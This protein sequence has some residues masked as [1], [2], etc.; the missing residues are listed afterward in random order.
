MRED[1][2]SHE[3]QAAIALLAMFKVTGGDAAR[4]CLAILGLVGRGELTRLTWHRLGLLLENLGLAAE[5]VE[6]WDALVSSGLFSQS[7]TA[8]VANSWIAT[9]SLYDELAPSDVVDVKV[10]TIA[11]IF[12]PP[13]VEHHVVPATPRELAEAGARVR[14]WGMGLLEYAMA[15]GLPGFPVFW[16]RENGE[17]KPFGTDIGS[18]AASDTLLLAVEGTR[19][20][21]AVPRLSQARGKAIARA[22]DQLLRCG[23]D[24][25]DDWYDG[26][27]ALNAFDDDFV[28][29]FAKEHGDRG[30]CPTLDATAQRLYALALMTTY[31]PDVAPDLVAGSIRAIESAAQCILRWQ[32]DSGGWAI[33]RYEPESDWKMP[34][35]DVSCRHA[36][37][38]LLLLQSLGT[39][40]EE[41]S[42]EIDMALRRFGD[43][44]LES[45]HH[46]EEQT[47]WYGDFVVEEAGPRRRAT[48]LC[49][50]VLGALAARLDDTRLADLQ[51][52]ATR[53]LLESWEPSPET[54]FTVE[55]RVP[56]W[57]GPALAMFTWEPPADAL[58]ILALMDY[59]YRGG[60]FTD[61]EVRTIYRA[62]EGILDTEAHGSWLDTEMAR[63]GMFKAFP[64][65]SVHNLRCLLAVLA[66]EARAVPDGLV[67]G[68]LDALPRLRRAR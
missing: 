44:L 3:S 43:L 36:V 37:E 20:G 16:E 64:Q 2:A 29:S 13:E 30:A 14:D 60:V 7:G 8:L 9:R 47:F 33:H 26:A 6:V 15:A 45:A 50:I 56:T 12:A 21:L 48:C 46:E 24:K 55:F 39:H 57:D 41:L 38:A 61:P 68:A 1:E 4:A 49:A 34:I 19:Y 28:G 58:V 53:H 31:L 42:V 17:S 18:F 27:I 59:G 10:E 32:D 63:Q 62:V 22:W 5:D 25:R 51:A 54:V 52:R 65:N 66:W 67:A 40:D 11:N 23:V 35:R